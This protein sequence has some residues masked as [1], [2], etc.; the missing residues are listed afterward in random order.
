MTA[1]GVNSTGSLTA[2]TNKC[3]TEWLG[4]GHSGWAGTPNVEVGG[5]RAQIWGA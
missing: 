4:Q 2:R 1:N 3:K 5:E